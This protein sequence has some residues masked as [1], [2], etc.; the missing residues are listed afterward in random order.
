M[1]VDNPF[2][3]EVCAEIPLLSSEEVKGLSVKSKSVQKEWS[4]VPLEK[5][6][7]VCRSFMQYFL[8]NKETV[9]TEISNQMGKPL[10]Q[11]IG[12]ISGLEERCSAFI[13]LAPKALEDIVLGKSQTVQIYNLLLTAMHR[14]VCR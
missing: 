11:A 8:D 3:G 4:K 10:S 5:R 9:A 13:D 1:T 12:E 6:L 7:E 14:R 2:T